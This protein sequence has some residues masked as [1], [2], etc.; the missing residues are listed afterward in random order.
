MN[1][2]VFNVVF[3]ANFLHIYGQ[4]RS[5]RTFFCP[6]PCHASQLEWNID[7]QDFLDYCTLDFLTAWSARCIAQEQMITSVTWVVWGNP[8]CA[9]ILGNTSHHTCRPMH[10]VDNACISDAQ[11]L[12]AERWIYWWGLGCIKRIGC[13]SGILDVLM[14]PRVYCLDVGCVTMEKLK[15]IS[16]WIRAA[17]TNTRITLM[18][19]ILTN[20]TTS[21]HYFGDVF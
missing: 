8:S 6:C 12:L 15:C 16:W 21:I 4:T 10:A 19:H 14:T 13:N 18:H 3:L 2:F 7:I 20:F 9:R 11:D 1:F 17:S 5:M